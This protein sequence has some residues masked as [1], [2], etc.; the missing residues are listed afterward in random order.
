MSIIIGILQMATPI[1]V[2]LLID[3]VEDA[4]LDIKKGAVLLAIFAVMKFTANLLSSHLTFN[5]V[6]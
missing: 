2:E 6:F 5:L 3:F 4:V 1:M